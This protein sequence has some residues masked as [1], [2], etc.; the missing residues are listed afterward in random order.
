ME[1]LLAKTI[2]QKTKP[3]ID[4]WFYN[5]YN[6][7]LYRGCSHGCIYCDSRSLC[8]GIENFDKVIPKK[9]SIKILEEEL[10]RKRKKGIIGMGSM[11]DPYNPLEKK[12]KNTRDALKLILKY[13]Y[14]TQI[15]TKSNLILRDL[16][17]LKEINVHESVLVNI[18]V[19]TADP[20]LQK[21]IEPF[22]STTEE[23]FEALKILNENGIKA[24]ITLM[25]I[26]PYVNDTVEN[27][28]ALL[29]KAKAAKVHHIYPWFGLTMRDRQRDYL[30]QKL[31]EHFPGVRQKYER[32]FGQ[33]YQANS[34]NSNTLYP[35]LQEKCK[36][37]GILYNI[38]DINKSFVKP[39][40]QMQLEL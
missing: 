39:P 37:Y 1:E 8:Y 24:G 18:T 23:R 30:Y 13:G 21:I 22:S 27:L 36:Q 12:L 11:S 9:D 35:H 32:E 6:M 17:L 26:L 28:D 14:G 31:D 20:V 10:I 7:N 33:N 15:I 5:D 40:K 19:T 16:D 34:R 3:D 38:R 4:F 25:P 29:E 2:L